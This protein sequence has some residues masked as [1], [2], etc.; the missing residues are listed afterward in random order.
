MSGPKPDNAKGPA[1]C[2]ELGQLLEPRFFKALCDPNRIAL[3]ARLAQCARPCTVSQMAECCPIDLSVVS[4]HLAILRDTGILL[5]EKRGKE[6][7]YSVD[8]PRLVGT[9]RAV[10]DA[11][12]ACCPADD[13]ARIQE[14]RTTTPTT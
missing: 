13:A 1:C 8:Y 7:Y 2:P 6:V 10:A 5:A 12:D 4:R 9:L 3:V 14:V 11:I